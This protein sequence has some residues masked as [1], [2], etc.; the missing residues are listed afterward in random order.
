MKRFEAVAK[1]LSAQLQVWGGKEISEAV[2]RKSN[3]HFSHAQFLMQ[4][5]DNSRY[6]VRVLPVNPEAVEDV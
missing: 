6:L 5:K 1:M 4:T 2:I 3:G